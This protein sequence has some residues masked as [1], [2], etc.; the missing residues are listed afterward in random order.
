[1]KNTTAFWLPV[2]GF[3]VLMGAMTVIGVIARSEAKPASTCGCESPK[4][5]DCSDCQCG[6]CQNK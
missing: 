2:F 5:C 1:M 4:S 6:A 3:I